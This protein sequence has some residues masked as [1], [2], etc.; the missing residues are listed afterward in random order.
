VILPYGNPDTPYKGQ[1]KSV[2]LLSLAANAR[3]YS[4]LD[5]KGARV[6][7]FP[8]S[9]LSSGDEPAVY[10]ITECPHPTDPLK[11]VLDINHDGFPDYTFFRTE[12][13]PYRNERGHLDFA[14]PVTRQH[15]F[16][17]RLKRIETEAD[18]R[19]EDEMVLTIDQ[20]RE[21]KSMCPAAFNQVISKSYVWLNA[22]Q[23]G[24]VYGF[25][26]QCRERGTISGTSLIPP[27]KLHELL[28][29]KQSQAPLQRKGTSPPPP[30]DEAAAGGGA[31][32][33][34]QQVPFYG[35]VA[36]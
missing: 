23:H 7:G 28:P 2:N 6:Q 13:I 16:A 3:A 19:I 30:V 5:Q 21:L 14:P 36:R 8:Y 20:Y 15:D 17:K 31:V 11:A 29:P 26:A 10:P 34:K 35:A 1:I 25:Q 18:C 24:R 33:V 22:P 32:V 27:N 12:A 4:A 9:P